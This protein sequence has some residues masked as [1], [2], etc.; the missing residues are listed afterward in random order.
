MTPGGVMCCDYVMDYLLLGC[1]R[2]FV[3]PTI[4]SSAFDAFRIVGFGTGV[5]SSGRSSMFS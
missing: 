2:C 3:Q 1:A 5:F 4:I